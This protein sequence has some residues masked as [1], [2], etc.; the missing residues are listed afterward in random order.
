[1]SAMP[2]LIKHDS[3]VYY[4]QRKV[5][6]R[7]QTAVAKVL[8]NGKERLVF[9]KRSLGT[10]DKKQANISIKPVLI[11]FDRIIREADA[12]ENSRPPA[13]TTLTTAEINRMA[14]YIYAKTLAWDD[15]IRVGGR[16]ELKRMEI[17]L[18][19][20]LKQEGRESEPPF[21]RYEDLPPFGISIEQ[22]SN[23]REQLEDDLRGMKEALAL[24]NVSAVAD[25]T[26]EALYV[27]GINLDPDSLSRPPLGIALMRS[28]VRAL[29]DIGKRNEGRAVD[30]PALPQARLSN[31]SSTNGGTLRDALDGWNKERSRPEDTVSEYSRAV[32]MFIQLH[33]NIPVAGI[34]RSHALVFR[35]ALQL[36]PRT[37]TGKLL[38]AG[39]PELSEWGRNHPDARKVSAATVNKQ[40][41]AVQAI[42]GWGYRNGLVSDDVPWSDAFK[43]KRLEE[44]QSGRTSFTTDDLKSI[45]DTP[46]FTAHEWPVGAKG[47]A[48][49]WLPLLALFSGARQGEIAGLQ[50][51]NV[52]HESDTPLLF[53]VA[54]HKSGKT[55]KTKISERVIPV[56]AQLVKL[57]F[58][59]YVKQ[60]AREGERAWLFPT[61]APDQRRA[62]DAWSKWFGHY[63]R[64]K[65][66][67]KDRNKVFHSFRHRFQDALRHATPD[68]ELRDAIQGRSNQ[69]VSRGYGAKAMLDR[70]GSEL[71]G[72]TLAK[73]SYPGLDLS[74]VQPL[75][76]AKR[77]SGDQRNQKAT[78]ASITKEKG[79][80]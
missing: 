38:K 63:L 4:A 66:K 43:D 51:S 17:E 30:T 54:D 14:E 45:F 21:Y 53:I 49:L 44:E 75:G 56:H 34:K 16:D 37:R 79:R 77:T 13:R 27:F 6:K 52:Q 28:Y 48:C 39:L 29:E 40:L 18:R 42:A 19:K 74:R 36:V 32:E 26:L 12:L 7:L 55:L 33:G 35:E 57:G 31:P 67:V 68:E 11:D 8:K 59:E 24:G 2:Y 78:K 22:L 3:G 76:S 46:L 60:R 20:Q 61:V 1:M 72:S 73:I 23:D 41:G 70:W 5:P 50:V 71:L 62:L 10:T 69:S 80:I 47:A 9:L 15:R 25:H 64:N 65:A 58:L